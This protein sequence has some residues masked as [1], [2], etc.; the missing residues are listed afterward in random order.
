MN[1]NL[2]NVDLK[3]HYLAEVVF[4]TLDAGQR[5]LIGDIPQLRN[6][7]IKAIQAHSSA[8][9]QS[10][11]NGRSV[12]NFTD[13]PNFSLSLTLK[14]GSEND[15][16]GIINIPL[17]ALNRIGNRGILAYSENLEVDLSKSYVTMNST[18]GITAGYCCLLSFFYE[19]I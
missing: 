5:Y 1:K 10:S 15:Q 9:F 3:N 13:L 7:K 18:T 19:A 14:K 12:I 11:I 4:N 6:V 17:S 8:T 16:E 2:N